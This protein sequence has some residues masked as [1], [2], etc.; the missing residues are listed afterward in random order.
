MTIKK[1]LN[2]LIISIIFLPIFSFIFIHCYYYSKSPQKILLTS[3]SKLKKTD[4]LDISQKDWE[5]IHKA[6]LY[7]SPNVEAA[8]IA[9]E[10]VIVSTIPSLIT[11]ANLKEGALWEIIKKTS[12]EYYYQFETPPLGTPE[13]M[14]ILISRINKQKN[15]KLINTLLVFILFISI[16]I[17]SCT[18][19]A[20]K[21]SKSISTSIT[22]LDKQTKKISEGNLSQQILNTHKQKNEFYSLSENLESMRVSLLDAK[23]MQS[24]FVM[25]IS[26]DLRTPIS[27]IKGYTEALNDKVIT[28][29][30]DISDALNIIS[31]KTDQLEGMI[32]TLINY[33]KLTINDLKK[34]LTPDCI[35]KTIVEFARTAVPTGTVFHRKVSYKI[36]LSDSTIIMI[37]EQL[38]QRALENLFSNALRYTKTNDSIT[39]SAIENEEEILLSISDSGTGID[40]ED[41]KH[42]FDLFYRGT[43]SRREEGLGIGLSVVKD[44]IE[45]HGWK[46][47]IN[48]EINKGSEFI[49]KIPKT[50]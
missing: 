19:I 44:I 39:I 37:N 30:K 16:F 28:S 5:T 34:Q 40:K 38:L 25:G 41:V 42:L 29:K 45:I 50:N 20:C 49:I 11:G 22:M 35:K 12:K 23:K 43:N 36:D 15:H 2:L 26:H 9:Q 3:Y 10:K 8:L 48:S 24:R 31:I 4:S 21:I 6:I 46:I 32:N 27:V 14:V 13:K 7:L 1:Q 33:E 17:I 18:L 47:S